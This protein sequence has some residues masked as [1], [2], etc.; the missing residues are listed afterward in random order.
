MYTSVVIVF[1]KVDGIPR[2]TGPESSGAQNP[3]FTT[4]LFDAV[5]KCPAAQRCAPPLSPVRPA[6]PQVPFFEINLVR[7]LNPTDEDG[8][9][10]DVT[11]EA[12][13]RSM[14]AV[15]IRGGRPATTNAVEIHTDLD[16]INA[17]RVYCFRLGSGAECRR[18][19]EEL[20]GLSAVARRRFELRSRWDRLQLRLKA[21]YDS[22]WVQG[23]VGALILAVNARVCPVSFDQ[24]RR[25]NQPPHHPRPH[26]RHR[27][28]TSMAIARRPAARGASAGAARP[29]VIGGHGGGVCERQGQVTATQ[30]S[31]WPERRS[32][33]PSPVTVT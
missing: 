7:A 24:T 23:F 22:D 10:S 3:T 13:E 25:Q 32:N 18:V 30:A 17:G 14:R 11:P 4:E 16:G 2:S 6:R 1:A 8:A 29:A 15:A 28:V 9:D 33:S 26:R 21:I 5:L 20:A 27:L 12:L 19:A 31:P